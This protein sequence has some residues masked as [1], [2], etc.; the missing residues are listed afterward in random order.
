MLSS[1]IASLLLASTAILPPF[2]GSPAGAAG[3][4]A[5]QFPKSPQDTHCLAEFDIT[6][7]PGV[8]NAPSSGTFTSHGETG[9][10]HCDGPVNGKPVTGT[11]SRGETG[12]YGLDGPNT[13]TKLDG[14]GDAAFSLT[15]PTA[16]GDEHIADLATITYGPLQGGGVLGGTLESKRMYGTFQVTPIEGDCVTTPITRAH[17]RCEEWIVNER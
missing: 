1:F 15:M 3:T 14:R 10:M 8:S 11:G 6:F 17:V 4:S 5:E 13:C 12:R 2:A 9:T 16:D 7:S